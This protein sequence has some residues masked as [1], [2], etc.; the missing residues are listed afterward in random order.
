MTTMSTEA[1]YETAWALPIDRSRD[2]VTQPLTKEE[3]DGVLRSLG[4]PFDVN[5]V[6]WRITQWSDDG[7]HGLMKPYAD[8]RAYSD[9]LDCLFTPLDAQVHGASQRPGSAQ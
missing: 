3:L 7:A 8:S 4:V 1:G 6:Q 9:R 2:H 5:L